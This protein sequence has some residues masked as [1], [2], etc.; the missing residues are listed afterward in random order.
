MKGLIKFL[1]LLISTSVLA[2]EIQTLDSLN[3]LIQDGATNDTLKVEAYIHLA[4][5]H[6]DASPDKSMENCKQA[7]AFSSKI[8]YPKGILKACGWIAYLYEQFGEIDS[9]IYY[10][11]KALVLAKKLS[12]LNDQAAIINNLAAIYKNQG[13]IDQ[14]LLLHQQG[15]KLR[16]VLKDKS[17][18][19]T[20]FNNRALIFSNQGKIPLA[21]ND[22]SLALRM[23]ELLNDWDGVATVLQNIGAV[24]KE[25][26]DYAKAL[27]YYKRALAINIQSGDNYSIAYSY[28]AIGNLFEK[29]LELDS[30]LTYHH[31]SMTIRKNI[32]DKQG[33]SYSLL[34]I[35]RVQNLLGN[36]DTAQSYFEQSLRGFEGLGDKWGMASVTNLLGGLFL[37]IGAL[38]PA[39]N[40]LLRSMKLS[41]ELGYPTEIRNAAGNLQLLYRHQN[42]WLEALRM[43]DLYIEMRDSVLN[44]NNRKAYLTNQFQYDYS[45]KEN[46]L[47][48]EQ[49]K[50]DALGRAEIAKQKLVRN[51]FIGGFIIVLLFALVFFS[52]RNKIRDGKKLSDALLLNILPEEIAEELKNKG[53]SEARQID[54]VTVLFTD[55]KGFTQLS[56]KLSPKELVAEIDAC[57]SEFDNIMNKH[58]VEKIKTIGD[59]YMAAGGIPKPNQTHAKDVVMAA[60][61]IRDFMLNR[62]RQITTKDKKIEKMLEIRIGIHTGPV[63]AGIVG[64]K[65]YS[66]DIW[67][68]TVNTAS[69]MESSGEPG[70]IN[71]SG[72]TYE[73][74]KDKFVCNY[75]GKIAAKNKGA[76]DMYFVEGNRSYT[77]SSEKVYS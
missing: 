42:N 67:G 20:V 62:N 35:G 69:R 25:Q 68:D 75:R 57:F 32:D 39:E 5:L 17:G 22:F 72:S 53:T 59:A 41:R 44:D 47:K 28:G 65:K 49:E 56:E 38:K 34:N 4:S 36:T 45:L 55:F 14:A 21:L 63:V 50:K 40:Y 76:I 61:E 30:A 12:K 52:Q 9:A 2:E 54:S 43:N 70:Q 64:S 13:K 60:L 71:I 16:L 15:L 37:K 18:V 66:Y 31:K 29:K 26:N 6:L 46:L 10:N 27:E 7:Y 51:G 1:F 58:G 23:Y 3:A 11:Q 48:S 8:N 74:I 19:A 33:L 73:I 24:Y 77:S